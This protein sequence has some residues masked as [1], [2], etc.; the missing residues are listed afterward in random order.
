MPIA[1]KPHTNRV[2][3]LIHEKISVLDMGIDYEY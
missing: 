2:F 1:M 3:K